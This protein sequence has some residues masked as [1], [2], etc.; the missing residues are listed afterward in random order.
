MVKGLCFIICTDIELACDNNLTVTKLFEYG[1]LIIKLLE[2][3]TV[4]YYCWSFGG[5]I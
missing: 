4:V 1:I 5:K 3:I 2:W